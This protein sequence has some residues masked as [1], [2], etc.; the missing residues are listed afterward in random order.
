MNRGLRASHWRN[1][2]NLYD[3]HYELCELGGRD[4]FLVC[5]YHYYDPDDNDGHA[6]EHH[7]HPHDHDGDVVDWLLRCAYE[8]R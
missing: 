1:Q 6:R 4:Q 8:W 2:F 3:L 5:Y 7:G